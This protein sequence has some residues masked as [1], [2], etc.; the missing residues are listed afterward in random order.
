QGVLIQGWVNITAG[1]QAHIKL[2]SPWYWPEF[3]T[4]EEKATV[5]EL[6]NKISKN[7]VAKLDLEDYT[8]AMKELHQ[9]LTGTL[10]Y[11]NQRKKT[12]LPS[13]T[14]N[15]LKEGLRRSWAAELIGHLLVKYESEWYADEA[16][17]KW[18]EI[19]ELFEEEK[20]QKKES[21]EAILDK[22]GIIEPYHRDFAMKK[23]D[24]ALEHVKS[25]WQ[26]EKEQRI[27][28]SLWWKEV[29][30]AQAQNPTANTDANTPK[31]SNLSAD[32]KAWFIHPVAMI[33]Y[34]P[35]SEILFQKGDKHEIIREINIRLAGFGGNVPT[36][37]FTERTEKMIKQFQRD[38][39]QVEETGVVD[40]QVIQAIDRFQEEYT[41]NNTIWLQLKCRCSPKQCSGFGNGLGTNTSPEKYNTYEFPGI[42][43]SLLFGFCAL[44]FYLGRQN[45]YKFRE[46]SSGYRCHSHQDGKTANHRGKALDIQFNKGTWAISGL[47]KNNIP[48]LLYIRDNFFKPYL[49]T[50]NNWDDINLFTTEPI[51][52]TPTGGKK[53]GHTYSWIHMDVRSFEKQ[54]LLDEYFCTDATTLNKEK[55]ITLINK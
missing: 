45:V 49:N 50:Q 37:E 23:V 11:S 43:R 28:P 6:S 31:L 30:Q 41:I 24:E 8:P 22:I 7:K 39:M 26:L 27:K 40:I 29:A 21:I 17:S 18:N 35:K 10:R 42:H 54:Y 15:Y 9:I 12:H 38:Y 33:D 19:D 16:L 44:N 3:K 5:G 32:G 53:S 36:D 2:V 25:N 1:A 55:L 48:P 13:F 4:V 52:L 34:F 46:I 20:Q 14:D 51:G 47:N